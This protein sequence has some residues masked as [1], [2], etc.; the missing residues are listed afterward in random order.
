MG[1]VKREH[2]KGKRD[3]QREEEIVA[4]VLALHDRPADAECQGEGKGHIGDRGG[5]GVRRQDQHA[6]GEPKSSERH[7]RATAGCRPAGPVAHGSQE[8][9]GDN[10]QRVTEQHFMAVPGGTFEIGAG[11]MAGVLADPEQDR[12]RRENAREQIERPKT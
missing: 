6:A 4:P 1:K 8:E 10:R 7:Q 2:R 9:T 3:Q 12:Q 5:D 11:Q